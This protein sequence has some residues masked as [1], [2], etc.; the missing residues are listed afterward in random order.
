MSIKCYKNCD[1][2]EEKGVIQ[3]DLCNEWWHK[4]CAAKLEEVDD[5][6]AKLVAKK[7]NLLFWRCFS[8]LNAI[9]KVN[10][11][12]NS[13]DCLDEVKKKVMEIEKGLNKVSSDLKSMNNLEKKMSDYEEHLKAIDVLSLDLANEKQKFESLTSSNIDIQKRLKHLEKA[14]DDLLTRPTG[15]PKSAVALAGGGALRVAPNDILTPP[16]KQVSTHSF[17]HAKKNARTV[18]PTKKKTPTRVE[19]S[20]SKEADPG[21]VK[22]KPAMSTGKNPINRT[23]S[24][25]GSSIFATVPGRLGKTK[26]VP[27]RNN[28]NGSDTP[29]ILKNTMVTSIASPKD[30]I[31]TPQS[32]SPCLIVSGAANHSIPAKKDTCINVSKE[33]KQNTV[34][35]KVASSS[36]NERRNLA[37][38]EPFSENDGKANGDSRYRAPL[39]MGKRIVIGS[40]LV[41]GLRKYLANDNITVNCYPGLRLNEL[42]KI[43][44]DTPVNNDVKIVMLHVGGNDLDRSLDDIDYVVGDTYVVV[45]LAKLKFPTA[46]ILL[47]SVLPRRSIPRHIHNMF[48]LDQKWI[49]ESLNVSFLN[50]NPLNLYNHW[51][52][53][54]THITHNGI[55]RWLSFLESIF[56]IIP[57]I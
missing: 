25:S 20:L 7:S 52:R 26:V 56:S 42:I 6:K 41:G 22:S 17:L 32:G 2:T 57:K 37:E 55:R 44:E 39:K 53:D 11:F 31:R 48:V 13:I 4:I 16:L 50:N 35:E 54:G 19:K 5:I 45:E 46:K 49:A 36:T 14:N 43:I 34:K 1:G 29:V 18:V 8:C 21:A 47:S 51:T 33:A 24:D 30:C 12:N 3:C 23:R 27:T 28:S 10:N 38:H 40:S 9:R 15:E